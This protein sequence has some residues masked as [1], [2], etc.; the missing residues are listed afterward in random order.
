MLNKKLTMKDVES[1]D[2]EFYNSM[3]WIKENNIEECELELY[4]SVDFEVL[5]QI[6]QHELKTG[7]AE[8]QVTEENKEDY[9][10]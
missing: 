9:I 3:L 5:G 6:T 8:I 2:P 7:G 10:R 4:F 1:I